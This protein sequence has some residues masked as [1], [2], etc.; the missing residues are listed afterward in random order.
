MV[1]LLAARFHRSG[2]PEDAYPYFRQLDADGQLLPTRADLLATE[3]ARAG[4]FAASL[5][6]EVPE[7]RRRAAARPGQVLVAEVGGRVAVRMIQEPGDPGFVTV[8]I[9]YRMRPGSTALPT[10]WLLSVAAAFFPSP[11]AESL[12]ATSDLGGHPLLDDEI[13][14]C[15]FA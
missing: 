1:W 2:K 6:A 8:A 14:F 11:P 4:S 9:S 13:A 3:H 10:N 5:I 15:D 12:S 7:L